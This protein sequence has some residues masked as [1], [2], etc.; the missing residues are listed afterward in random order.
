MLAKVQRGHDIF[1]VSAHHEPIDR[2][3]GGRDAS[4]AI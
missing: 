3:E 4:D 1:A 2:L